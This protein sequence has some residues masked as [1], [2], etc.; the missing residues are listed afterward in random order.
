VSG[1][2]PPGPILRRAVELLEGGEW[3]DFEAVMRELGKLV[4]PGVAIRRAERTR[5]LATGTPERQRPRPTERQIESGKRQIVRETIS[6][7]D[8]ER[9]PLGAPKRIRL[10]SVP[11]S[12]GRERELRG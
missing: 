4:P 7:P 2:Q 12:I 9:D 8:F 6:R 5:R 1:G 10:L 3:H 11:L